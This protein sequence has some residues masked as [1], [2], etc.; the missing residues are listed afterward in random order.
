MN[1]CTPGK[2][3]RGRTG[4]ARDLVQRERS[5]KALRSFVRQDFA[6][7]APKMARDLVQRGRRNKGLR[8]FVHQ[9]PAAHAPKRARDLVQ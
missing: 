4:V 2:R 1:G 5:N 3:Q 9:V 8:G 6:D 7:L